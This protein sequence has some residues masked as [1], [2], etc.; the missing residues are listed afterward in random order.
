MSNLN[1]N[2]ITP[3]AGPSGHIGVSGSLRVLGSISASGNINLG[4]SNTDSVTL[5]ADVNSNIIPN[6]NATF[7]LGATNKRWKI[8][9][10]VTASIQAVS[11]HLIPSTGSAALG[12]ELQPWASVFAYNIIGG[13]VGNMSGTTRKVI[14]GQHSNDQHQFKGSITASIISASENIYSE[15]LITK[16]INDL[17]TITTVNRGYGRN[18]SISGSVYTSGS[19][20]P[21]GDDLFDLGESGRQWKD[22]YVDG[23]AYIDELSM[24]G[25]TG[26][27]TTLTATLLT[28]TAATLGGVV[29]ASANGLIP[30]YATK[31]NYATLGTSTNNWRHLYAASASIDVFHNIPSASSG[32]V[33]GGLYS[34]T[35]AQLGLSGSAGIDTLKFILIK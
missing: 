35:G 15:G 29:S 5:N 17:D 8:A 19:I 13:R 6:A 16:R 32:A 9:H 1:V 2:N 33:S 14:Y 18:L 25:G 4:D 24:I 34:R 20:I 21:T 23:T 22:L 10:L 7:D 3:L 30:A 26:N 27:I 28:S 12:L 11:S 31:Y